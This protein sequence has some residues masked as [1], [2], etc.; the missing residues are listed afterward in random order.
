MRISNDA[1][2]CG[3]VWSGVKRVAVGRVVQHRVAMAERAALDV[4]AGQPDGRAVGEDRRERQFLGGGPVDRRRLRIVE[5]LAP[6]IAAALEL[7][8]HVKAFGRRSAARR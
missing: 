3:S 6:A 4:L 5:R 7:A 8:V 1:R 2:A